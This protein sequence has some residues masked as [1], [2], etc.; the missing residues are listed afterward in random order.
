ML[1]PSDSVLTLFGW[2]IPPLCVWK[3]LTGW[4]C[5]GCGLTRSFTWMGHGQ[6]LRALDRNA[7]GPLLYLVV[8]AQIPW[9][10]WRL[11]AL[12]RRPA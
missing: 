7:L 9:R 12:R 6:P 11:W 8:A 1:T 5:P 10:L 4:D 3:N 2:E